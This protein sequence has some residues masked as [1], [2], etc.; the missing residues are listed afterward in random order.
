LAP[1]DDIRNSCDAAIAAL[2]S[3]FNSV[4]AEIV[5][6]GSAGAYLQQLIQ[7]QTD[8]TTERTAIRNAATA[9]V[10]ALPSVIAAAAQLTTLSDQMTTAAQALPTAT[11]VLTGATSVLSAGQQFANLLATA[12]K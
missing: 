3:A 10:L 7:R 11:N 8:L 4:N 5:K 6:P 2:D 12:Q 9:A 1:I